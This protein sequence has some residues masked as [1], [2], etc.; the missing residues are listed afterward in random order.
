M[1]SQLTV[2]H[3]PLMFEVAV[4]GL[5]SASDPFLFGSSLALKSLQDAILYTVA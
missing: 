1:H 3:Y 5:E 2:L 4:L